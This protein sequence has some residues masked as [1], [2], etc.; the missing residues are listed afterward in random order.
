MEEVEEFKSLSVWFDRKLRGKIH[1]E[2]MPNKA[3]DWVAKVM[4]MSRVNGQVEVY[5]GRMV[6]ERI[7]RQSV[8]HAAEVWLSGGHSAC[9]KLESAQMRLDR[10]LLW[11]S[12]TVAGVAV[13]GD[14]GWRKLEERREEMKV[15]L[16]NDWKGWKR[17]DW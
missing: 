12:N 4:W 15:L 7:G 13:Q 8:K 3:E 16:G 5:R 1:L 14:L 11:A 6:W 17:V 10:S 9:R 2:K